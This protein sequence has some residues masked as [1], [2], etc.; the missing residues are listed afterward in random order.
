M[1]MKDEASVNARGRCKH[2][3]VFLIRYQERCMYK[4]Q[5]FSGDSG[6]CEHL[7]NLAQ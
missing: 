1:N 6:S 7:S 5:H 4:C 2:K 3:L